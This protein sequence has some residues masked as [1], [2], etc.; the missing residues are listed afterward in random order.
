MRLKFRAPDLLLVEL[1]GLDLHCILLGNPV[2]SVL[3]ALT[4]R[5][6]PLGLTGRVLN[7]RFKESS[8]DDVTSFLHPRRALRFFASGFCHP[9]YLGVPNVSASSSIGLCDL[10]MVEATDHQSYLTLNQSRLPLDLMFQLSGILNIHQDRIS[11]VGPTSSRRYGFS[12][13]LPRIKPSATATH[14]LPLITPVALPI[15]LTALRQ[16]LSPCCVWRVRFSGR[17]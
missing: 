10:P 5:E 14:D 16:A 4:T 6:P 13:F 9:P 3:C 15:F 8:I 2:P 7:V 1:L 12:P 11:C 17:G